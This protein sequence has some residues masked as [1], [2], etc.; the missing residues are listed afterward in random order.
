MTRDTR[1]RFF[2]LLLLL[3]VTSVYASAQDC[4]SYEPAEVELTG[5]I[6][7]RTFPGPP[8]YQSIRRGDRAETIWI[9]RLNKPV[10]VT[11]NTDDI[12]TPERRVTDLQLVLDEKQYAQLRPLVGRRI[13]VVV[14][15]TLFHSHTA[16][17]RTSVLLTV[18]S[19]KKS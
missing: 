11:G 15:G 19:L 16:H 12:N 7:K 6:S 4:L 8:N 10:C 2:T 9:L 1:A 5:T 3:L 17:H 18:K 13:R 14:A